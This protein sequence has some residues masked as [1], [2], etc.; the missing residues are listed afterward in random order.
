V[1]FDRVE[2]RRGADVITLTPLEFKLL[3]VFARARG[4]VLSREQLIADAWG[5]G[6]FV[7]DRVVDNHIGSLRKKIEP[8]AADPTYLKNVRGIGYRFDV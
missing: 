6:T 2:V 1:D 8:D 3:Q 4:R 7:T 5:P